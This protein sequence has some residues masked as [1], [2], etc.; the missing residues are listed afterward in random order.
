M[1]LVL[2]FLIFLIKLSILF[3]LTTEDFL[4]DTNSFQR[5]T[6]EGNENLILT[7]SNE[8]AQ[9]PKS[10]TFNWQYAAILYFQGYY[11]ETLKDKKMFYFKKAIEYANIAQSIDPDGIDGHYWLALS[12]A[13]WSEERGILDS[14]YYVE[15]VVNEISKVISIKS[16]FLNGI[17][18]IIRAKAYNFAPGW[19]ISLGNKAKSYDDVRMALK[20]GESNRLVYMIYTDILLNDG[21]Y[22]E[23]REI[24][25]K[26]LSLPFDEKFFRE[27][28]A[29]IADLRKKLKRLSK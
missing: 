10:Y 19:P 11:Y 9:N 7:L 2:L 22:Q 13:S 8:V 18:W 4:N 3:P 27:E 23:C 1:R 28:E 24:I 15:K 29:A 21:K 20:F 25:K 26:A 16:N 12:Y 5:S 6:K 14:L 17:P